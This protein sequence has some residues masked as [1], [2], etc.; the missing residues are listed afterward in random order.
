MKSI[1][2]KAIAIVI[3]A[4]FLIIPMAVSAAEYD[5]NAT[6][7]KLSLGTK[8]Y[9]ASTSYNY[10]VYEYEPTAEAEYIF[11]ASGKLLG[12]VS[13]NGMW[14]NVEPSAT[15]ITEDTVSWECTSVGQTIWI[16]VKNDK[17]ASVSIKVEKKEVQKEP[18]VEWITYQNVHTPS[19]FTFDGK[20]SNLEYVDTE[21]GI[22][23]SP[24]RDEDGFY[25]FGSE[26]GPLLYVDLDDS[27]MNLVEAVGYGKL[28]YVGY[29]GEKI[30]TK[31]DF[32]VAFNAYAAKAD[33]NT[34]LYPLTE[35]L[36]QIYK[37][38]G[39]NN[40]WYG[41]EGFLELTDPDCWMFACY[42]DATLLEEDKDDEDDNIT[43]GGITGD[44][45]NNNNTGNNPDNS[46]NK[47]EEND[48]KEDTAIKSPSTGS[49]S[50]SFV[51]A[52]MILELVLALVVIAFAKKKA[53]F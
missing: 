28:A 43:G 22:D 15:T 9:G 12:I 21:D 27:M 13:Y 6:P 47:N 45:N 32:T 40:N 7:R 25:H 5:E 49:Q 24:Y 35:D 31:I 19:D 10:T 20:V 41:E 52:L 26:D 17:A 50:V 44:G 4:A 42:Y 14:V 33:K 3:A 51:L 23:D 37:L 38:V 53:D 30:V 11:T 46:G 34:M 1:I 18:E 29:D 36:I 16:A 2:K 48:N 8:T 39:Q